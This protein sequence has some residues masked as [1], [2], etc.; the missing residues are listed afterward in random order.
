MLYHRVVWFL[1][2][3]A[4]R[5]WTLSEAGF[6]AFADTYPEFE[7]DHDGERWWDLSRGKLVLKPWEE[8]RVS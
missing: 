2:S 7:V 1:A 8:N 6:A 4:S 5:G 3:Y